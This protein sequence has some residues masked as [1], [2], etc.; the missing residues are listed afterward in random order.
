MQQR[1]NGAKEGV[2]LP[3]LQ[4]LWLLHGAV[5]VGTQKPG[6]LFVDM[7]SRQACLGC[8]WQMLDVMQRSKQQGK[9]KH[10][11]QEASMLQMLFSKHAP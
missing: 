5:T 9:D 10:S 3:Q 7:E 8:S 2:A 11:I 1:E 4:D 6:L